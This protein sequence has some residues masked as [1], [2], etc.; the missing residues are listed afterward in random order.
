MVVSILPFEMPAAMSRYFYFQRITF[1]GHTVTT[2]KKNLPPGRKARRYCIAVI[3]G[4]GLRCAN[5]TYKASIFD[6]LI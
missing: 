1:N 5:P 6:F 4:V 3:G 2:V